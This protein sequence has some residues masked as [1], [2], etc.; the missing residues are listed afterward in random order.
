M[1]IEV[2]KGRPADEPTE[3]LVVT[4]FEDSDAPEGA[5]RF[6]KGSIGE[7]I[8]DIIKSGDFRGKLHEHAV[9]YT[10]D[11]IPAKRII[12][13]GLG[14]KR[15]FNL[16]ILRGAYAKAARQIRGVGLKEFS[17]YMDT[18]DSR[19]TMNQMI[20]AAL[21]GAILG[22]Y[23]FTPYKTL[24]RDK[25]KTI[26]R[27]RVIDDREDALS[28]IRDAA[29]TAEIVTRAVQFARDLVSSP[30]NAMTPSDMAQAARSIAKRKR[31]S[32]KVLDVAQMKKLGMNAFL[33]VARGSEEP[34]KF[35]ILEYR[36][37]KRGDSHIVLVG[38]GL[39][40]DSG[41]ISIKPSENMGDMKS[42]MA[43]GAAVMG[44]IMAAADLQLPLNVVGLVPATENLPGGCAYKPGDILRSLSGQTIEVVN[45][46]AEGRLILADALTYAQRFKPAAVIDIATL[47]GACKIAL[48]DHVIGMLGNDGTL[49]EKIR[50]AGDQTGERV[51]ELPLWE[52]YH[53]LIASDVA[54]FKN[55]GSRAGGAITAAAFLSKFVGD[56]PWVHLDIAGPAWLSKDKPYTPKGATG[57]GVRLMVQCLRDWNRDASPA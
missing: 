26:E 9:L 10:K 52:E 36:G 19:Q 33:G 18:G 45:T 50:M 3:A 1:K 37:A 46:D 7:L 17:F 22:L 5:A 39:T 28:E 43:G 31:V 29:R 55:A 12:L 54:D 48:G 56:T 4:C 38:K 44:A 15:K 27:L 16:E 32:V 42:D 23:Q 41:G 57:V 14:P 8:G 47:T 24:E 21:E 49:K 25:I 2:K 30:G 6:L 40:F 34:A 11:A 53:E 35:I 51:W 13:T 20:E